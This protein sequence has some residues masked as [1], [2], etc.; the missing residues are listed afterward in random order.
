M[1]FL[2][3]NHLY[4]IVCI[5]RLYDNTN[6]VNLL[7]QYNGTP[8][9]AAAEGGFINI[10]KLLLERAD[11]DPNKENKLNGNTPLHSAASCG[12]LDIVELLLE[13]ADIDPNGENKVRVD[14]FL[15]YL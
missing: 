5:T 6:I 11:I 8:L 2:Y 15:S 3:F 14:V 10:V 9:H 4:D 12:N 1:F 13:R 7:F